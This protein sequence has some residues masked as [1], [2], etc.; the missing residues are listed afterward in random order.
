[1][2]RRPPRSTRTD[3]LFPYTTLFRSVAVRM[4]A[5]GRDADQHVTGFDAAAVAQFGLLHRA[6]GEAGQVV[7]ARRVHVWH[8]RGLAADQ[9]AAGQLAAFRDAADHGHGGVDIEL[10]GGDVVEEEQRLDRKRTRL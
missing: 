3:T 9:R 2:L 6:D 8:L 1:M 7:F 10:A 4:R 5:A